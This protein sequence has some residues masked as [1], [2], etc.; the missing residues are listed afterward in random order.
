MK[1]E[2]GEVVLTP[3]PQADGQIK[4][5]PAVALRLMPYSS[6]VLVCGIS[7]QMREQVTGFDEIISIY[8]VDFAASGLTTTSLTRLAFLTSITQRTT[9]GTI[10]FV[11]RERHA[12]LLRRLSGYLVEH[13]GSSS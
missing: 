11:A 10:G 8:D 9:R 3:L 4:V 1:V 6:D 12:W 13:L 5:R 7:T 2:E